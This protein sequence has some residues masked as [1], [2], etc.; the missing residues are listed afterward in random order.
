MLSLLNRLPG[1]STLANK[2]MIRLHGIVP[3]DRSAKVRWLLTELGLD[4]EDRWLNRED[5]EFDQPNFLRLN[6]M[7]RVPVLEIGDQVMFE[8]GAICSYL[9]DLHLEKEMAPQLS[10]P[11]RAEYQKW[12]YFSTSSLDLFQARIMAFEDIPQ[13]DLLKTKEK[14]LQSD[15]YDALEALNQ[16]LSR[17]SYLVANRFSAADICVSYHL[18]WCGFWPELQTV[19]RQFPAI[20]SYLDRLKTMPS[21]VQAQVFSYAE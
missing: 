5:K 21:A 4:F 6:P 18:Y 8:S 20:T 3:Y 1:M 7:G 11:N 17:N 12:M 9:A 13:E 16:V 19:I 15:L 14:A 2:S 10:S